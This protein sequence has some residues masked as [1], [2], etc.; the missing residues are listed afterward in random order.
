MAIEAIK[1]IRIVRFA[2]SKSCPGYSNPFT[3]IDMV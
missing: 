3:R 2:E 1:N